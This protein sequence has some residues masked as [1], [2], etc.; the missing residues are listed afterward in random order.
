MKVQKIILILSFVFCSTFARAQNDSITSRDTLEFVYVIKNFIIKDYQDL[1]IFIANSETGL[2]EV[3][4]IIEN[5]VRGNA[6]TRLFYD[7]KVIVD[8]DLNPGADSMK[9]LRG[10]MHIDQYL[11]SFHTSYKKSD[12]PKIEM[13]VRKV[14]SLNKGS[15]FYYNV[16]FTCNYMGT[17]SGNKFF[18]P[19]DR[20]AEIILIKEEK[21][22][23]YIRAIRFPDE[24]DFLD[25]NI[26]KGVVATD[27]D[28]EKIV[29][30][31]NDEKESRIREEN[32]QIQKLIYEGDDFFEDVKYDKALAKYREA[33]LIN[34]NSR[35]VLEKIDKTQK[36]ILALKQKEKEEAELKIKVEGMKAN[37]RLQLVNYNFKLAKSLCDSL[38]QDYKVS[39]TEILRLNEQLSEI[40]SSL[41]GIETAVER[42]DWKN[43]LKSCEQKIRDSKDDISRA[44][45]NFRMAL[46]YFLS[47]KEEVKRINEYCTKAI[48][49]SGKHHQ[50]ALKLRAENFVNTGEITNA[51]EDASRLIN[52][53]SR[54]PENYIF[55]ALIY[56][57]NNLIDKAIEDYRSAINYQSTE[58]IAFLNKAK[59]EYG[60]KKYDDVVKTCYS[61]LFVHSCF[62]LLYYYRG[63][64]NDKLSMFTNTREDFRQSKL[65]GVGPDEVNEMIAVSAR[66][67]Q[68][69][70]Q[71]L[72]VGSYQNAVEDFSKAITID[73]SQSGLFQRGNCFLLL[74]KNEEALIDFSALSQINPKSKEV[75][76][77]K[78]LSLYRL[79]RYEEAILS[80]NSELLNASG[81]AV[82]L[83]YK[84]QC[85][86]KL[87]R[88]ADASISFEK[89]GTIEFSDSVFYYA[90]FSNYCNGK[91]IKAI[92]MSEK[93]RDK[94]TKNYRVFAVA[95]KSYFA[96]KNIP[97]A[98]KEFEKA[99]ELNTT[100]E[101]LIFDYAVALEKD[102]KFEDA[103]QQYAR[104][105]KSAVYKDTVCFRAA[106][107]LTKTRDEANLS[108]ATQLFNKYLILCGDSLKC[109]VYAWMA[110]CY[111]IGE[112]PAV[113]GEFI[114]TAKAT[115]GKSPMLDFVLA[116]K[117]SMNKSVAEGMTYLENAVAGTY[118]TREDVEEEKLLRN[119]G[120][121]D[122]YKIVL[123]KRFPDK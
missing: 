15:Y 122:R 23:L 70:E 54:N 46:I 111:L 68:L 76:L 79:K 42:K 26:F 99:I 22:K 121:S 59:L 78:G 45:F 103:A 77:R 81:N 24:K 9:A 1:L 30:S 4:R 64:A 51:I 13:S 11:K 93:A 89:S 43:A 2:N 96:L 94:K 88:F 106:I 73:S 83:F 33:R 101:E 120:K 19:F 65:C 39:D 25:G 109:E 29:R 119:L 40:L 112:T 37:A 100:D 104:L 85:E 117:F 31:I 32:K 53:D 52:N 28:I 3:E 47:D 61:G 108:K 12:D 48:D 50:E 115:N 14:S 116:C 8:N 84:G 62:G 91:F 66:Y 49:F 18:A 17:T 82:A 75:F 58:K 6:E 38:I 107:V 74:G 123:D 57:K 56:E 113:A 36:A 114:E 20:V 71:K 118:F 69:G 86:L 55:R 44:E 16:L 92:E 90:A 110:Y 80:F 5:R 60:Q 10:E 34:V 7:D 27:T 35:D 67:V 95:G 105:S 72:S 102:R 97:S 21:W 98:I 41:T 63:L 87:D